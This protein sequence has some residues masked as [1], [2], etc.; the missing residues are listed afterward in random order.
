M[1]H[2]RYT[3][4]T[5][6]MT[7]P[8]HDTIIYDTLTVM[9]EYI[10]SKTYQ[11]ATC[12][13]KDF[14]ETIS[15]FNKIDADVFYKRIERKCTRVS[16]HGLG[17]IPLW[18]WRTYDGYTYLLSSNAYNGDTYSPS[19]NIALKY[20]NVIQSGRY[21]TNARLLKEGEIVSSKTHTFDF[22]KNPQDF[23]NYSSVKYMIENKNFDVNQYEYYILVLALRDITFFKYLLENNFY[24]SFHQAPHHNTISLLLLNFAV[25]ENSLDLTKLIFEHFDKIKGNGLTDLYF[26]IIKSSNTELMEFIIK[27]KKISS[28]SISILRTILTGCGCKSHYNHHHNVNFELLDMFLNNN[29]IRFKYSDFA[30][31][32]IHIVKHLLN[33]PYGVKSIDNEGLL[34][35][36]E[37]FSVDELTPLLGKNHIK[38][39][40]DVNML[41]KLMDKYNLERDYIK[42]FKSLIST[43]LRISLKNVHECVHSE[44]TKKDMIMQMIPIFTFKEIKSFIESNTYMVDDFDF[45]HEF[46]AKHCLDVIQCLA[47]YLKTIIGN[48]IGVNLSAFDANEPD[49]IYKV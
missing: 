22:D 2:I 31:L 17:Y 28:P 43:K 14:H 49:V 32:D 3:K 9:A 42:F 37:T 10:D 40:L 29:K 13:N 7:R 24:K 12:V 6:Y 36:I 15:K 8:I 34:K 44:P 46:A 41:I 39:L 23:I 4:Y 5:L 45:L 38:S 33:Y 1:V 48:E 47:D 27:N 30:H 18:D 19:S 20:C 21:G 25:E 11:K 16:G 26:K 35:L